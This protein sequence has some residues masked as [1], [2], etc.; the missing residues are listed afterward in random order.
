MKGALLHPLLKKL[1]L[2]LLQFKNYQ[3]IS[4]LTFISKLVERAVCEQL[5]DHTHKTS[6]LEDLQLAYRSD[7]S[8]E[9][10]LLKIKVDILENMDNQCVT[11]ILLLDPS[12]AF[13]TV[14][15]DILINHLHHWF[16]IN[17][18]PLAW[19]NDYLS[20][21]TQ[22]V[23]MGNTESS[24]A[25]LA[26]GVPR[27]SVLGPILYILFTSRVGDL[28]KKHN[29]DYH[30]YTDD[31]Q[32]YHSFSPNLPGDED[33]CITM[34]ENCVSDIRVWMRMN[35]LKL[36]DEK[37]EFLVVATRQQLAKVSKNIVIRVG[38]DLIKASDSAKNLGY[39][40]DST[41]KNVVHINKLC[42]NLSLTIKKIGKIWCN[43]DEATTRTLIQALVTS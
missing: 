42:S 14:S 38:P 26:Q 6:K 8:T 20:N 1:D 35:K 13:D 16:G 29:I 43:I 12:A 19:I 22:K 27:G 28:C 39:N 7:H 41:M 25:V 36:N 34:L 30:G 31:T 32:N 11:G 37:T 33:H 15:K 9:M 3:P 40:L 2:D 17:G 5:M 10:A 21:C 24:P 4:N 23:K 18:T